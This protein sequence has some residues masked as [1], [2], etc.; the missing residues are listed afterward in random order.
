[1]V[2]HAK[3]NTRGLPALELHV[4]MA[5]TRFRLD[6]GWI[7]LIFLKF[8]VR[9]PIC[10]CMSTDPSRASKT[11]TVL[12]PSNPAGVRR[13]IPALFNRSAP[14]GLLFTRRRRWLSSS[15]IS[16]RCGDAM[17]LGEVA[18][19]TPHGELAMAHSSSRRAHP[20]WL[21]GTDGSARPV[22]LDQPVPQSVKFC[23]P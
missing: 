14:A 20:E 18:T 23:F 8:P 7:S 11:C 21:G 17:F 5:N 6:G 16:V 22:L 12:M 3:I 13:E 10:S 9:E 15:A 2:S 1:M 19:C 4:K